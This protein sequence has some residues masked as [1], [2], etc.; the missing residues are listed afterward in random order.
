MT[1]MEQLQ[2]VNRQKSCLIEMLETDVTWQR[3]LRQAAEC[4]AAIIRYADG[5]LSAQISEKLDKINT[6]LKGEK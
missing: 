5:P 4:R 2:E 3:F 6:L 1:T